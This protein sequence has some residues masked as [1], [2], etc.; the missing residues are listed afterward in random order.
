VA[1]RVSIYDSVNHMA[2]LKSQ[3]TVG[4]LLS[5]KQNLKHLDQVTSQ[6]TFFQ[7]VETHYS[8]WTSFMILSVT[9]TRYHLGCSS[10]NSFQAIDI[11]TREWIPS[12]FTIL[13]VRV[14]KRFMQE[15][16]NV[17]IHLF[18]LSWYAR[19][20]ADCNQRVASTPH[21]CS[22]DDMHS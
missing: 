20:S 5:L 8:Q 14:Y 2:W 22:F 7:R 15:S 1:W 16:E 19:R 18:K 10:L 13:E 17:Y 4:N 11:F 3:R 6:C 9:D 21:N 12:L